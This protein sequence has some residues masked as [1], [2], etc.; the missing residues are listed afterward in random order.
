[1]GGSSI[2]MTACACGIVKT[3]I[4]EKVLRPDRRPNTRGDRDQSA[5]EATPP[6]GAPLLAGARAGGPMSTRYMDDTGPALSWVNAA[7]H[8]SVPPTSCA[9]LGRLK[10][11]HQLNATQTLAMNGIPLPVRARRADD[12]SSIVNPADL[13]KMALAATSH[14]YPRFLSRSVVM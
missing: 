4:I 6:G 5:P 11:S 7:A 8:V 10:Q 14:R 3:S 2:R 1:H 13:L 9:P 12:T